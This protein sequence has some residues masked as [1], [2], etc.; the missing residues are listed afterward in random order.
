LWQEAGYAMKNWTLLDI[1]HAQPSWFS[2]EN[3]KFF[4]DRQYWLKW[5][6][7]GIAFLLRSTYAWTDMFGQKPR[8]HYRLNIIN[9]DK[10]I[11]T[12]LDT[13]FKTIA[14]VRQWLQLN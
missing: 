4:N 3:K 2:K 8:L 5:S 9:D 7:A 12:M 1:R 14:E 13:E 6:S 11:G 10:S